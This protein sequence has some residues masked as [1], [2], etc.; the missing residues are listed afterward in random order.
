MRSCAGAFVVA[1]GVAV[2]GWLIGRGFE[3]AHTLRFVSV[4]GLAERD[5]KAD[6]ALWPINYVEAGNELA[7]VEAKVGTDDAAVTAFLRRHRIGS[8]AIVFRTL[9]V[10]DRAAQ[11]FGN[12]KY[13]NRFI[14]T[15]TLMV[16]TGD[17]DAVASAAQDTGELITAGVVLDNGYGPQAGGPTYVF[18]RLNQLKPAMIAEATRNARA[19][20]EQFARDSGSHLGGIRFA[21]QGVFQI[22]PRDNAPSVLPASKEVYKT[23][24]V[25]STVEYR[26]V[27]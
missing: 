26:L 18:S 17:V 15:R 1:V 2:A 16:R 10:T 6:R 5:V 21:S 27:D 22:L 20:A 9:N 12:N 11:T 4:K 13:P 3:S 25:V 23:V 7:Q 8:D 24:R 19:A 14:I